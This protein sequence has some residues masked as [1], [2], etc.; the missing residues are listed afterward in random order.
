MS[1]KFFERINK[2]KHKKV[3]ITVE[4]IKLLD[5]AERLFR[6]LYAE[7]EPYDNVESFAWDGINA[8]NGLQ[9]IIRHDDSGYYLDCYK[10]DE[11]NK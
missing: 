8:V 3:R 5:N 11:E 2:T 6:R 7:T 9:I 10:I 4:E 1:K